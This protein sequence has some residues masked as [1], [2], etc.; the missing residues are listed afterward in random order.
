MPLKRSLKDRVA[1]GAILSGAAAWGIGSIFGF[2]EGFVSLA[3]V[4]RY[5]IAAYDALTHSIPI[6]EHDASI[7]ALMSSPIV[8]LFAIL[9]A[10]PN[11]EDGRYR[12][13]LLALCLPFAVVGVVLAEFV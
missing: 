1:R 4:N 11:V 5:D 13:A 10:L 9:F 7:V 2:L 6:V 12:R 3:V 8:A